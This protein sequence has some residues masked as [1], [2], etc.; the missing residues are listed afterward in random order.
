[1]NPDDDT[2]PTAE[3]LAEAEELARALERGHGPAPVKELETAALLRYAKDRGALDPEKG[4]LILEDALARARPRARN[5]SW[6][7]VLLGALGLSAAAAAALLVLQSR[8]AP[9]ASALPAPPRALLDAQIRATAAESASLEPL[10]AELQPYRVAVY[11]A[12]REHY[13]R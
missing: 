1:M 10:G 8:P 13:G 7:V 4:Q 5:K 12:L 3:E 6:R 2:E 11:S 9:G